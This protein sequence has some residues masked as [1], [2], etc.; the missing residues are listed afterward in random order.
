MTPRATQWARASEELHWLL[1]FQAYL[2]ADDTGDWET[3]GEQA[4]VG[5]AVAL[6]T[7]ATSWQPTFRRW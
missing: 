4:S 3:H 7:A 2:L 5:A 1:L 6:L